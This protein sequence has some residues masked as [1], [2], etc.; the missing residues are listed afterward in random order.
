MTNRRTFRATSPVD[1]LA[2]VS[3]TFGFHPDDS[4]VVMSVG[5]AEQPFYARDDLLPDP[6][7]MRG[8][9]AHLVHV[10]RRNGAGLLV[11]LVYSADHHL[12]ERV[13]RHLLDAA[14]AEVTVVAAV[15]ADGSRWYALGEGPWSAPPTG[16]PYDLS[17][18]P[19]TAEA[20]LEG[21][22]T[23]RSRLELEA[24]LVGTDTAE[25]DA[26]DLAAEEAMGRFGIRASH[27]PDRAGL[28]R[29][30]DHLVQEGRWVGARVRRFLRDGER[31]TTA[32]V[33]RLLAAMVAIEVRDV[34]WAEMDHHNA[35]R[36]VDLWHDVVRRAPQHLLAAPAALLGFAAWLSGNGALAW[37]A[38]DRC[39][40]AEP[41][42]TLAGLLAQ[43]LAGAVP[44][45]SWRPVPAEMLPLFAG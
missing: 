29:A 39:H 40:E 25:V 32:E 11:L 43:A 38:V 19:L 7:A 26:V 35:D 18:H 27:P 6:D 41:D 9:V 31:L 3:Y 5:E 1:L 13:H 37:C 16:A 2:T 21:R 14:G 23:H 12:A 44:P 4:V 10:A 36:H 17:A 28:A 30:R 20:V 45:S 24:S 22:V 33:G 34:A 8:R 42:Y 15:R